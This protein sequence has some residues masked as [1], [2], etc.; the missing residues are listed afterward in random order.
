MAIKIN[1]D[2][3]SGL[4]LISD[5]SGVIEFQ[6]AGTT[7]AGVNSTGLTGNGSQL[8][9]IAVTTSASDLV[10]GTLPMARLSGTLPVLNGSALTALVASN[11]A[12]GTLPM[13]RLSGTLPALNGSALTNLPAAAKLS[14][15]SGSAPSYSA[16]AWVSFN[17]T[18]TPSIKASGNVSSIT[19]NGT[20]DYT[21]NFATAMPDANFAAAGTAKSSDT[22]GTR[23]ASINLIAN[24]TATA[25]GYVRINIQ[26]D[27][28]GT[29]DANPVTLAV[30]R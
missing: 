11:I 28:S 30:F 13:A 8:T 22:A 26:Y 7:R 23:M 3:S 10:S 15:A 18:G 1:A 2:T 6:T 29:R 5:T 25:T 27:N 17:G 21:I 9:G 19:D 16:R 14:T 12:S 20:G 24:A 4:K